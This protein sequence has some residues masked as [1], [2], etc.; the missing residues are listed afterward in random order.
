MSLSEHE[1]MQFERLTAGLTFDDSDLKTMR[2][3]ERAT[4]MSYV[5]LP[6]PR[7]ILMA[8]VVM[9]ACAFV[10]SILTR[11]V[12]LITVSCAF[13]ALLTVVVLLSPADK[14]ITLN[15]KTRNG[16]LDNPNRKMAKMKKAT[17]A[18]YVA[19]PNDGVNLSKIM[20]GLA[21]SAAIIAIG[22]MAVRN[23]VAAVIS[24]TIGMVICFGAYLRMNAETAA[25]SRK[26]REQ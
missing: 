16:K 26:M 18:S 10:A 20:L 19:S 8:L 9:T 12:I 15:R 1:K 13:S 6:S 17:T 3:R 11:N 5:A 25:K 2:K 4:A 22:F 7:T 23:P 14:F 24:G 21:G